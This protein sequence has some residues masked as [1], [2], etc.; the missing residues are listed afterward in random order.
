MEKLITSIESLKNAE[1]KR[2]IDDRISEF[3]ELTDKPIDEIFKELCFC[4]MTAN[5]SA[6]KCIEVHENIGQG[7][8]SFSENQLTIRFKELG[9][10]FPNIRAKYVVQ[11]RNKKLDLENALKSEEN[12]FELRD[13]IAKNIK[14]IGY[15]EASHFLRNI[16]FK[17]YGILDFHIIDIVV[18]HKLIEKPKSLTKSRYL[19]IERLFMNI[20][21][22]VNLTLAELDLYLWYMETSKILK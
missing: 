12:S 19:E 5:C 3:A 9:Y 8:L 2:S 21:K 18:K 6:E 15:K 22:K 4:I 14:G 17:N 7:F 16:G 11:A 13:W 1:V 10:R 20:G